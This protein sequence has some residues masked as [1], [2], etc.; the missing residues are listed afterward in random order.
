MGFHPHQKYASSTKVTTSYL[1]YWASCHFMKSVT[2]HLDY[3]LLPKACKPWTHHFKICFFIYSFQAYHSNSS[4]FHP[5][6]ADSCCTHVVIEAAVH[7]RVIDSFCF[8]C[9]WGFG[10]GF[11]CEKVLRFVCQLK[12][13]GCRG[14][15]ELALTG[16]GPCLEEHL[17]LWGAICIFVPL[18]T[19]CCIRITHC[20]G[21]AIS[22][23]MTSYLAFALLLTAFAKHLSTH[24]RAW[25]ALSEM[26]QHVL[27]LVRHN[28]WSGRLKGFPLFLHFV[29]VR[30]F[31]L[32]NVGFE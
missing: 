26:P 9:C 32:I 3:Y 12:S 23:R 29:H 4:T 8:C 19:A 13:C 14:V 22:P 1:N 17:V 5:T 31:F 24:W 30:L 10:F 15:K 28:F 6:L 21:C 11:R 20:F 16:Y 7:A 25:V 2:I 27:H 18:A